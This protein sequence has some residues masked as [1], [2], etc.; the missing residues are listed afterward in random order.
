MNDKIILERQATC[1][2]GKPPQGVQWNLMLVGKQGSLP[3]YWPLIR[4]SLE[5]VLG[6]IIL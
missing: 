5:P 1:L 2:H 3:C 4:L 6:G